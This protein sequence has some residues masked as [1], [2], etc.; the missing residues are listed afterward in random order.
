VII[1]MLTKPEREQ[2]RLYAD[3]AARARIEAVEE[4]RILRVEKAR[5]KPRGGARKPSR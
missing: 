1:R 2:L 4:Q 3:A 5:R